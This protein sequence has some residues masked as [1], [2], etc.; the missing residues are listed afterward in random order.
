MWASLREQTRRALHLESELP[1]G[2]TELVYRPTFHESLGV[3]IHGRDAELWRSDDVLAVRLAHDFT[4]QIAACAASLA[5]E[6]PGGRDGL[7]LFARTHGTPREF[8]SFTT[9]GKDA[10]PWLFLAREVLV[11]LSD[12]AG[13]ETLLPYFRSVS[14]QRE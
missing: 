14:A 7:M 2:T 11:A 8:V 4:Q 3:R 6:D 5:P 1:A 9:S 10:G 13:V 12:Q